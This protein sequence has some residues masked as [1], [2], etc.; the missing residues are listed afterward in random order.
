[1]YQWIVLLHVFLAFLFILVHGVYAA[2][3]LKF[4]G[5]SDPERSATFFN[6]VPELTLGRWLIA[7]MG[8]TGFLAAFLSTWWKQGWVWTSFAVFL[9]VSYIMNRYGA[10]YYTLMADTT[11]RLLE[12]RASNT[13]VDA[14]QT[15]F[16]RARYASHPTIVSVVGIVGLA[17][18]LWLMRFKPF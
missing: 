18:I 7:L 11:R 17:V 13:D 10:G 15:E 2:A 12:A 14:A 1:M 6:I 8:I 16:D 4:R 5:E 9:I 3:M